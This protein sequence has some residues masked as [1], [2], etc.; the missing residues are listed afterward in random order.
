MTGVGGARGQ[1]RGQTMVEFA[2]I[3]PVF[4]LLLIGLFDVGRAVFAFNTVNNAAREGA[5]LA[6]VD[7]FEAHVRE[8]A[9]EAATDLGIQPDDVT[10]AYQL[11]DGTACPHVGTEGISLCVAVVS[12]PYTY[13]PATPIIGNLIGSIQIRGESKFPISVSCSTSDCPLGS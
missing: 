9:A 1:E 8:E 12:V 6:I 11:P 10:V 7:Q 2:L 13:Q 3:L 5:R 4:V